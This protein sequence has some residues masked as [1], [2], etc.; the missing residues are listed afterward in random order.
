M[1]ENYR[2]DQ[3]FKDIAH[4]G[5]HGM[6]LERERNLRGRNCLRGRGKDEEDHPRRG[7]AQARIWPAKVDSANRLGNA[8][9]GGI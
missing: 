7:K 3:K 9:L 6:I 4:R 1:Q 8:T 5:L 2:D